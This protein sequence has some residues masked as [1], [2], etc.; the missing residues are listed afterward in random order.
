MQDAHWSSS[1]ETPPH[2]MIDSFGTVLSI[3]V[4]LVL[5]LPTL[6]LCSV[7]LAANAVVFAAG[8][9]VLAIGRP[10][11]GQIGAMLKGFGEKIEDSTGKNVRGL[12]LNLS[13]LFGSINSASRATRCIFTETAIHYTA[14]TLALPMFAI[15]FLL[16]AMRE[17]AAVESLVRLFRL[18]VCSLAD[19]VSRRKYR[20]GVLTGAVGKD[21]DTLVHFG[22]Y[23]M[24]KNGPMYAIWSDVS[25]MVRGFIG[26]IWLDTQSLAKGMLQV[27]QSMAYVYE[28]K[29]HHKTQPEWDFP[30]REGLVHRATRIIEDFTA[31]F[32]MTAQE[33]N[34]VRAFRAFIARMGQ[35][36]RFIPNWLAATFHVANDVRV[37]ATQGFFDAPDAQNFSLCQYAISASNLSN[38]QKDLAMA[39]LR[40]EA[41]QC[42]T[43]IEFGDYVPM[44]IP[45]GGEVAEKA[46]Q[47]SASGER[48]DDGIVQP[49]VFNHSAI[50]MAQ[51]INSELLLFRTLLWLHQDLDAA[52]LGTD[53][54]T[55]RRFGDECAQRVKAEPLYPLSKEYFADLVAGGPRHDDQTWSILGQLLQ[56]RGV[57]EIADLIEESR[58]GSLSTRAHT[59]S[60]S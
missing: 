35:T 15:A 45:A 43:A 46:Y 32:V 20:R 52:L 34:V 24:P 39:K 10:W 16:V 36:I 11:L 5:F 41:C 51:C 42:N 17:I 38:D 13:C 26:L 40:S 25:T 47:L 28:K 4:D 29:H 22:F 50:H 48:I 18:T 6:G 37:F 21:T 56:D 19:I 23:Y 31:S 59:E 3:A 7:L 53:R 58:S 27:R 8:Y 1:A 30:I 14:R 44:T 33:G 9:C 12:S 60:A 57:A 2:R 55:Q 54:E 49:S